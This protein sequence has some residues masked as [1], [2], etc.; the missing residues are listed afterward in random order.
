MAESAAH[1]HLLHLA[2]ARHLRAP[3]KFGRR[4]GARSLRLLMCLVC[5]CLVVFGGMV[6]RLHARITLGPTTRAAPTCYLI[7]ALYQVVDTLDKVRTYSNFDRYGVHGAYLSAMWHVIAARHSP[8]QP[9]HF[10][11]LRLHVTSPGI[12]LS[13]TNALIR[14]K[15]GIRTCTD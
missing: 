14:T 7:G 9:T 15:Y 11:A 2:N 10:I 5:R 12:W 1:T 6:G 8:F 13:I 3:A 4:F